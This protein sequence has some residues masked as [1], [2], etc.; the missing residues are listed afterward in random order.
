MTEKPDITV[1]KVSRERLDE[2]IECE[3]GLAANGGPYPLP[4]E[5]GGFGY[6]DWDRPSRRVLEVMTGNPEFYL[7]ALRPED[8]GLL[9]HDLQDMCDQI[10]CNKPEMMKRIEGAMG[11]GPERG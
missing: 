1:R 6:V 11:G 5:D 4:T 8:R 10:E 3:S 7:K 9:I 2:A